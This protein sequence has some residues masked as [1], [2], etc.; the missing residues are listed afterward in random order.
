[1]TQAEYNSMLKELEVER[2]GK[3][4]NA[5]AENWFHGHSLQKIA[6][7]AFEAKER[8]LQ[9]KKLAPPAEV[10][11]I[12]QLTLWSEVV[13]CLP[14]E[15]VNSALFSA[16]NRRQARSFLKQAEIAVIGNGKITFTGEELRQDDATVWLQLIHLAKDHPLGNTVEFTPYALCKEIKW[17]INGRSYKR[18]RKCLDRMQATSLSIYSTR[19]KEGVSLSMIPMFKWRDEAGKAL[20][21]YQVKVAPELVTLFSK[22][23]RTELEWKQRLELPDGLATWLHSYYASHKE[24]FP[25]KLSTLKRG[26]GV[27]TECFSSLRQTIEIALNNLVEVEF[28]ETW[29]IVGGLVH[30]KRKD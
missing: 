16:K 27:T 28:L 17:S 3:Q 8:K 6:K 24:P 26:A 18:L 19:L 7:R 23:Y 9:S 30:V 25:I 13:R 2:G 20:T 14:N 10:I 22:T 4:T 15:I 12:K 11:D 1:M 29:K 21:L 5:E